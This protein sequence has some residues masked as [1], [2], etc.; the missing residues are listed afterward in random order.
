MDPVNQLFI[1]KLYVHVCIGCDSIYARIDFWQH[2][3]KKKKL[4]NSMTADSL[5][6][7][8]MEHHLRELRV[9]MIFKIIDVWSSLCES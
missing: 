7:A 5:G 1:T 2:K 8:I 4:K 3:K 9:V 6:L